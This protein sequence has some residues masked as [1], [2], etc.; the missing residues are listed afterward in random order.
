MAASPVC[1]ADFDRADLGVLDVVREGHCDPAVGDLNGNR[2]HVSPRKAAG[3]DPRIEVL[4]LFALDVEGE[5]A[6]TRSADSLEG[7][8]EMQLDYVLAVGHGPRKGVHAV[9][10][11]A[12]E[13][14]AACVGDLE[15][16]P[17]DS[18]AARETLVGQPLIAFSVLDGSNPP[19]LIRMMGRGAGV[20]VAAADA[21]GSR[22]ATISS[23]ANSPTSRTKLIS[24]PLG[25]S[26]PV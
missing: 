17:C 24:L 25:E 11:R 20:G 4:E 7:F 8:R 18:L 3:L 23:R 1:G 22:L 21:A 14:R 12:V 2:L 16:G 26:F 19:A 5:H 10:F 13:V 6:L 9:A 15:E